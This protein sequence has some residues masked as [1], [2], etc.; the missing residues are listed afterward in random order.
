MCWSGYNLPKN[1]L[2]GLK[3]NGGIFCGL[4][5]IRLFFWQFVRR[6]ANTEFKPQ[7]TMKT[8]KYG[9]ASIMIWGCFSYYSV[10]HIVY[11]GWWINLSTSEKSYCRMLKRKC[12]WNG[13]F[14]KTMTPN[15]PASEQNHGSRQ[16]ALNNGVAS[17]IPGP[18]SHRNWD[19][20]Q[21][22]TKKVLFMRQ[23]QE[24]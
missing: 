24:M 19:D 22:M 7:Y 14:N 2:T 15:T 4:M 18:K 12:L 20:D 6:P 13:C 16:T 17:T 21:R 9:G 1:T 23:H 5:R 8:M 11:Q 3:R 10:G